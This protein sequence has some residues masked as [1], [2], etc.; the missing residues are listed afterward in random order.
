MKFGD[1]LERAMLASKK[2]TDELAEETG[3]TPQSI[4]R[5]LKQDHPPPRDTVIT[6]AKVTDVDGWWPLKGEG[7]IYGN[8]QSADHQG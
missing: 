2:T 5:W 6:L 3:F 4:N 1:R 7:D 8:R